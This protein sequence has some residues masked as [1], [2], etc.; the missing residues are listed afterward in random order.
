MGKEIP[1]VYGGFGK[2]KKC[3]CDKII[4]LLHNQPEKEIRK[5]I[6]R[7]IARFTENVDFIDLKQR[8]NEITTLELLLNLGYAKQSITQ[9]EHIYLLSQRGYLKLVKIMDSEKAWDTYNQVID[10]YFI[11]K[12]EQEKKLPTSYKEA[13]Q[14][15]IIEIEE[16]EKLTAEN[17][18]QKQLIEEL[19][20]KAD[21]TELILQNKSVI[22]ITQI[23]K[24]YGMS[25][26]KFNTL[27]HKM[28]IQYKIGEQWVLYANYQ[29]KGCTHSATMTYGDGEGCYIITM[30]T[31]KGRLFLYNLLKK[32]GILP[33]IEQEEQQLT[34]QY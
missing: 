29:N 30:R 28:K 15:L 25:G 9:A 16:K 12:E 14:Q 6:N 24:D 34:L 4:A 33:L 31:Q 19:K 21:Y 23:A 5:T 11:M 1:I 8:G 17:S 27:L 10:E 2:D 7:N 18:Q 13:L 20:P 26:I 22:A 3:I 32:Q